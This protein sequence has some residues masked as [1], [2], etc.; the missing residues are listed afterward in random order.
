MGSDNGGVKNATRFVYRLLGFNERWIRTSENNPNISYMSLP[1]GSYT[2]CVRMLNDDGSM[3]AVE[4]Q[5]EIVIASPWYR[6]WWAVLIYLLLAAA[7]LW[8]LSQRYSVIR[9]ERPA[10]GDAGT[11]EA[12]SYDSTPS[13]TD[14]ERAPDEEEEV[15]EEA[16][17]MDDD[18]VT[19][20]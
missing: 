11:A 10:A 15:I 14:E 20:V 12:N 5:L 7:A 3:G 4:S 19:E 13:A 18:E 2:L 16:V 17:L 9:K 6:S 1:S 8:W